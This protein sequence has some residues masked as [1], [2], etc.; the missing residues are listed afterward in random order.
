MPAP[1]AV[2]GYEAT[3]WKT[4]TGNTVIGAN[5]VITNSMTL[6][7]DETARNYSVTFAIP[8]G[9]PTT[10]GVPFSAPIL[11]YAPSLTESIYN[12]WFINGIQLGS[13]TT[14]VDL[15]NGDAV[16]IDE[17]EI[18]MTARADTSVMYRV[19]FTADG[20]DDQMTVPT[21]IEVAYGT[22]LASAVA[23]TEVPAKSGREGFCRRQGAFPA[24]AHRLHMQVPRDDS[25]SRQLRQN[26]RMEPHRGK[27]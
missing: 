18:T 24:D 6:I 23:G 17:T 10:V 8:D 27:Q 21:P 25:V 1:N 12:A 22:Y 3:D 16:G 20:A 11:D 4:K 15:I 7:P 14:M 13:T 26:V 5:T 19:T 2:F 9:T